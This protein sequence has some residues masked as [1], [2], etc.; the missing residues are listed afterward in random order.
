MKPD[1]IIFL[2]E[3]SAESIYQIE[4][5]FRKAEILSSMKV[6]RYGNEAILYLKGVGIYGNRSI[7]PIPGLIVL[8]LGLPDGS[9]LSVLGWIRQQSNFSHIPVISMVRPT[10]LKLI[11]Q[12]FDLGAN[13]YLV[14]HG[15]L[16]EL[17]QLVM[18]IELMPDLSKQKQSSQSLKPESSN[19]S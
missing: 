11:Q 12:A 14:K 4:Q 15:N 17:T 9:G 3:N 10:Q 18:S 6:A 19:K 8:D 13:A 5:A 16:E 1:S 2:I 7:Y